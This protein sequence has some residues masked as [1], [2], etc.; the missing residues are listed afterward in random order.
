MPKCKYCGE[1][2][3]KFDKE[4]CPFCGEK[5]P[6]DTEKEETCDVTQ[7]LNT[8]NINTKEKINIKEHKKIVNFILCLLLG[9]FGADSF[10]LGYKKEGFIRILSTLL[11]Y[12]GCFSLFYFI[13]FTNNLVLSLT[14]PLAII[15]FIYI[16]L[17]III[18]IKRSK[19]HN[20]V[21]LR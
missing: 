14:I 20:G 1:N 13:V 10:Y 9:L 12:G 16:V 21:F 18:L 15:Y 6:I 19:D 8:V 17:S 7:T 2:I 3:T 4:I 11:I 5:N